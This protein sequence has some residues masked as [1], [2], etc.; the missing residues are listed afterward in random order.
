M[1]MQD[2]LT[3]VAGEPIT[4]ADVIVHLKSNGTFRS[5]IYHVIEKKVIIQKC[6]DLDITIGDNEFHSHA[7][8]KR[9]LLGLTNTVDLNRYCRW[10]GIVM[11]QWND[12]VRQELLR[13]KLQHTIIS[14]EDVEVFFQEH[15]NDFM[16]ALV[17]RIVCADATAIQRAMERIL[18]HGEDFA[19]V[20]RKVSLEKNT[21]IA[22]GYLGCIKYGTLPQ[23]INQA[24]FSATPGTVQGPFEQ[25]GYWVLYRTE[26]HRN[27]VLDDALRSNIAN[28][29]FSQWLHR[30][31][32]SAKA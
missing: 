15:K 26:D 16:M 2:T 28:R 1:E 7:E 8:I 18:V 3:T 29:L 22:G 4:V 6:R 25:S 12:L 13:Q 19:T 17:S 14:S 5:A 32:L 20:A 11:E 9:R 27:T 30:A 24:V 31:V 21:R 23:A 10:H